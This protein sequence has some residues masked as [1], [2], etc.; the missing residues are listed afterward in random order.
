MD[1]Y[2]EEILNHSAILDNEP[3]FGSKVI[4]FVAEGLK[5]WLNIDFSTKKKIGNDITSEYIK[6]H[7]GYV[8]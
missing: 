2:E 3:S 8:A 4:K 5:S 1:K 6:E 7:N